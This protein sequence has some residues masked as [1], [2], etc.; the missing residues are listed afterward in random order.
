M[1]KVILA[2]NA[3]FCFGVKRA[4]EEALKARKAYNVPIYTLGPL[5]HNNDVVNM[6]QKEEI[7]EVDLCDIDKLNKGDVIVIRS[8]GVSKKILETLKEKGLNIIDAT[9]PYVS[10]IHKYVEKYHNQNYKIII[11][12]DKNH[13]EVSG[14]NGWCDDTAII[15]KDGSDLNNIPKKVCVVSQTTEKKENWEKLLNI[16]ITQSKEIVALNTICE[17]TNIRQKSCDDLSK[18]VDAM[19]VIGGFNSSNTTKLYEICKRNCQ[20]TIHVENS[21]NI[22]ESLYKSN[23]TIGV[24]AGASTPDFIIREA[25]LKMDNEQNLEMNEQLAYMEQN[26]KKHVSVGE[27]VKGEILSVNDNEAFVN[28]GYK[29]DG[30]APKAEV[31]SQDESLKDVLKVGEKYDFKVISFSNE[32][33]YLVLSR[34]EME[35]GEAYAQL[36]AAF[37]EEKVITVTVKDVVKGGVTALYKRVRVFIPASHLSLRHIQNLDEFVGK[38]LE[39]KIIEYSEAKRG[40]KIIGS[41]RVILKEEQKKIQENAFAQLKEGSV[42]KGTVERLTDFGAF[43]DVLGVDGLLHVSEISWGRINKP[44]D[45]L[46]VSQEVEVYV[47]G[48]DEEKKKISLSL[49]KLAENPWDGIEE[50]YPVG[51]V[52]LGKVAR[53]ASFGAF[54]ELEPGVDALVHISQISNKRIN[55]PDEVLEIGQNIKAKIVEVDKEK[56]KIGLS[57]KEV[58]EE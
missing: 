22:P 6:L 53:F 31:V 42:V 46:K 52:V 19:V 7:Y 5:I 30:I 55:K 38:E 25:I 12:G 56:K 35:R 51:S 3:G 9:C 14:I 40:T 44:S 18:T 13:P 17:A 54:V 29:K 16:I 1:A 28:I 26:D 57:I 27:I 24:T 47:L 50:K 36:E 2:T 34:V 10:N 8:H 48:I 39:V 33:G 58:E 23:K 21:G 32:D 45:V 11:L 4:V 15:T 43:V 41:R 49:K 20:N 37:K